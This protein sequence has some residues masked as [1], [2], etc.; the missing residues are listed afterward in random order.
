MTF[1]AAVDVVPVNH[2]S[3]HLRLC[4][5]MLTVV[6]SCWKGDRGLMSYGLPHEGGNDALQEEA[7]Q[8]EGCI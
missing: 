2:S 8:H 6:P 3:H 7:L 5:Y 1:V 4:E